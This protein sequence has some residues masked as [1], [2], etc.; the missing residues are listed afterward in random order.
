MRFAWRHGAMGS[1]SAVAASPAADDIVAEVSAKGG[2]KKLIILAVPVVLL[3]VIAGLWFGGILPPLLGMGRNA[4]HGDAAAE[5]KPDAKHGAKPDA[6]H[7]VKT[8]TGLATK[9]DG[10]NGAKPA[11]AAKPADGHAAKPAD[12]PSDKPDG[13]A[14]LAGPIFAELP[15]IVANLNAGPR[16]TVFVKLRTRIEL[17]RPEDAALVTAAMPR[18]LDLFQ[19]YLREMR[20][21]ELRGSAGTYRLREELIARSNIA[22]APARVQDPRQG[23]AGIRRRGRRGRGRG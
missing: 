7:G 18:L 17:V 8:P 12:A 16:R 14:A 20:P 19:T 1:M 23:G 3:A 10:S 22:L 5:A 13:T 9:S 21:E 4:D 6:G 11:A 15:D 2:K